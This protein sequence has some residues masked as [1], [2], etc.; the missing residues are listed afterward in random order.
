MR[1]A[2]HAS[3]AVCVRTT[4][5]VGG[6]EA[7]ASGARLETITPSTTGRRRSPLRPDHRPAVTGRDDFAPR[8]RYAGTSGRTPSCTKTGPALTP[9]AAPRRSRLANQRATRHPERVEDRARVDRAFVDRH[10]AVIASAAVVLF[11]GLRVFFVSGF[12]APAALT[13]L[14][15]ADRTTILFSTV[16]Y[17]F[18]SLGPLL[19]VSSRTRRWM[20]AGNTSGADVWTQL[21]TATVWGIVS[22]ALFSV[23]TLGAVIGLCAGLV[24]ASTIKNIGGAR[25][26][27][28][29][30]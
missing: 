26:T 8:G 3:A 1:R 17:V 5:P 11:A 19:L 27:N 20:L 21:R 2:F 22:V 4:A 13:I 10:L 25:R 16:L 29:W 18:G 14:S 23:I 30:K 6:V 24:L 9:G 28:S 15:V 7:P 12:D